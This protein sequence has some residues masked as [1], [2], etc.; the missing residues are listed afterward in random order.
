MTIWT[1]QTWPDPLVDFGTH[2]Y[3]PWRLCAGQL[4][5]RDIAYYNGPL[6]PYFNAMLFRLFGVGI[7]TLEAAN[8]I[9]LAAALTLVYRLLQQAS[10]TVA[11]AAGGLTFVLMFAFGQGTGIG[12][13]NWITPY[14]HEFTHGLTLG[15]AMLLCLHRY[16]RTGR[17]RWLAAGG[18]ACGLAFCT[19][20]E[21]SAAAIAGGVTQLAAGLWLQR[22]TTRRAAASLAIFAAATAA[23]PLAAV[24]ALSTVLPARLA[25]LGAAGSW[26]WVFDR[27]ITA[28]PFYRGLIGLN[29][30]AGNAAI[31]LWWSAAYLLVLLLAAALAW[32]LRRTKAAA[33]IVLAVLGPA[34]AAAFYHIEWNNLARPLPL[35]LALLLVLA[36]RELVH[37]R[38]SAQRLSLRLAL[39]IFSLALL[40]KILLNVHVFH[41]GFVLALPG[42][43]V[44][45]AVMFQE[46]PT[47]AAEH[48]GAGAASTVR[49]LMAVAWAAAVTATLVVDSRWFVTKQWTMQPGTPDSFC[50][51][52]RGVEVQL[53]QQMIQ[54][55]LP[56]GDTLAVFPQGLMLNYLARRTNPTRYVNF[57]P[58]EVLA[59]GEPTILAALA[60]HP[61]DAV[62]VDRSALNVDRT[63]FSLDHSYD[64]GS[65]TLA[66]IKANYHV[67][68]SADLPPPAPTYLHLLLLKE[69]SMQRSTSNAQRSTLNERLSSV[70]R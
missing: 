63:A 35:A 30:P 38:G 28:L 27:R 8:A 52:S 20:A 46:L 55:Q 43:L 59:A 42:T 6:S 18:A 69:N 54:S 2:C 41:Y 13:Y 34:M 1:W 45:T 17:M 25:W 31:I 12:N 37:R 32:T 19:K 11:A 62:V 3:V 16:L 5:Y 60:A 48:W 40:P 50:I 53:M 44:L 65:Q 68:G 24:A 26:A 61:P 14:A 47:A 51:A 66:W 64:Y 70:E 23:I 15:L 39:L 33:W 22:A 9:V 29:D 7:H 10:G 58:P 56:P 36:G 4:L 57:M 67:I 49:A 21:P